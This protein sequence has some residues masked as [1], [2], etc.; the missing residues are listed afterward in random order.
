MRYLQTRNTNFH[1][2]LSLMVWSSSKINSLQRRTQPFP[3]KVES[4]N[5]DWGPTSWAKL[6]V[7]S[8][9][10]DCSKPCFE[11]EKK[12]YH[13]HRG[14]GSLDQQIT[15]MN[16]IEAN[17]GLTKRGWLHWTEASI[18]VIVKKIF[19]DIPDVPKVDM[20]CW[21]RVKPCT[22]PIIVP[23]GHMPLWKVLMARGGE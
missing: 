12:S 19:Y 4:T 5:P 8:L 3:L 6:Y 21:H 14:G 22:H 23:L 1:N 7:S 9:W 16:V 17:V 20:F 18:Y 10:F 11:V 15:L 13:F 2:S